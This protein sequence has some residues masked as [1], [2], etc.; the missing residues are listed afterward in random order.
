LVTAK[1]FSFYSSLNDIVFKHKNIVSFLIFFL[2]IGSDML[3]K[4]ADIIIIGAGA[5]GL[6]T[7]YSLVLRGYKNIVVLEK[8]NV[9]GGMTTSKCAGGIRYQFSSKINIQLS[10]LS[11]AMMEEIC[12]ILENPSAINRCGYAFILTS[13]DDITSYKESIDLQHQ[14]GIRTRWLSEDDTRRMFPMMELEDLVGATFYENDGLIDP[15]V[16][17]G[18][19]IKEIKRRGVK[20]VTSTTVMDILLENDRI[21]GV[22]TDR[23][24]I[25]TP[26]V[27]CAAGPWSAHIA[28]MAGVT[29]PVYPSHQQIFCTDAVPGIPNTFPVVIFPYRGLGF[30][31]EGDGILSGLYKPEDQ[32]RSINLDVDQTWEAF[33]CEVALK[34]MPCLENANILTHWAGY[35]DMTPDVHPVIGEIQGVNGF[36]CIAGFSGH[37]FMHSPVCGHLL[38]EQIVDGE[39][40]TLNIEGLKF[41]RFENKKHANEYYR[42]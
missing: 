16:I 12:S 19:F 41:K 38:C 20:I 5:M 11:I 27:V 24:T 8:E 34:R 7:A 25:Q 15:A 2:C 35:Y 6:S 32:N 10:I 31:R 36:Y 18:F 33:H 13:Q 21:A 29:L 3:P 17:T 4:T 23:G 39:I 28:G 26:G 30:H 42:I 40:S 22:V 37:G 1:S 9:P 14:L